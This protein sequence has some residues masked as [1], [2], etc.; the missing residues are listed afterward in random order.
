MPGKSSCGPV[1]LD[2]KHSCAAKIIKTGINI[3]QTVGSA[4]LSAVAGSSGV[5][6]KVNADISEFKS[7]LDLP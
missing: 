7:F 3:M 5:P 1:C 6:V 2:K 4:V